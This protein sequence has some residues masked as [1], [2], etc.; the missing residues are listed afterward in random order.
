M[1]K[2]LKT[3]RRAM[4]MEVLASCSYEESLKFDGKLQIPTDGVSKPDK[5]SLNVVVTNGDTSI[6]NKLPVNVKCVTFVGKVD[7]GGVTDKRVFREISINDELD[8]ILEDSSVPILVRVGEDFS[9]M[10]KALDLCSKNKKVRII[11]GNLLQIDGV[12]IGRYDLGKNGNAVVYNG[13]YDQFLEL[14]LAEIGDLQEVVRK[15]RNKLDSA[16]T[17]PKA[18]KPKSEKAPS[19]KS[20]LGKTFSSLFE[21][22]EEE[23]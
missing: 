1:C 7:L 15:A 9:D 23:F 3:E 17:E 19:R 16:V 5:V 14:P 10:R 4:L 11:G 8:D 22:E 6:L 12:R 20:E 2:R 18:K 13:V 21:G